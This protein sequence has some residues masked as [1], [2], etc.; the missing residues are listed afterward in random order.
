MRELEGGREAIVCRGRV[1]HNIAEGMGNMVVYVTV[2]LVCVPGQKGERGEPSE[3]MEPDAL[4]DVGEPMGN[5]TGPT[6]ENSVLLV[7]MEKWV[8]RDR[9]V[10]LA[11]IIKRTS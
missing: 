3:P 6:R 7:L 9:G 1:K 5:S 11:Q 2:D 10:L 4:G 8:I